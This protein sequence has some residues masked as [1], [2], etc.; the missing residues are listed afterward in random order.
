MK[1][2]YAS[3]TVENIKP[4]TSK[5]NSFTSS[6]EM[7]GQLVVV[8]QDNLFWLVTVTLVELILCTTIVEC[9]KFAAFG[10]VWQSKPAGEQNFYSLY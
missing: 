10:P 3:F 4:R 8:S 7:S 6:F 1:T 2:S 9:P 5:P